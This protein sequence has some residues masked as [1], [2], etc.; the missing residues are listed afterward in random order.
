MSDHDV[1]D[2]G[3]GTA[4]AEPT[5]PSVL[6]RRTAMKVA[7]GGAAAATVWSAPRIEGLSLVPDYAAAAS[8]NAASSAT[9]VTKNS[10]NC[11][12]LG[13]TECFGNNC[14]GN[15]G[16]S[17]NVNAGSKTFT[18]NGNI[19]GNVNSDNGLVNLTVGNIDPPFQRCN[20]N[21]S[22]NCNNDGSA[23][24]G[25]N[26]TFNNNGTQSSFIDC[27]GGGNF[28]QSDPNAQV[29]INITC[30]CNNT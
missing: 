25:G 23:R 27:Q 14:C 11:G 2:T 7:L 26:F 12:T 20:V 4:A 28:N 13:S 1:T 15:F 17:A 18:L 16:Y 5:K 19:G 8:C 9:Q 29:R 30:N 3:V 24:G 22:L 21:V 10:N 6:D